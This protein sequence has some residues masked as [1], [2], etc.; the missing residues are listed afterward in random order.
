MEILIKKKR[1]RIGYKVRKFSAAVFRI[2]ENLDNFLE[3]EKTF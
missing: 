3:L 1:K 2:L